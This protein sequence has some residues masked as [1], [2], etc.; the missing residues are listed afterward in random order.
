M[1]LLLLIAPLTLTSYADSGQKVIK[2]KIYIA[3]RFRQDTLKWSLGPF[4]L[5]ERHGV[6]VPAKYF[7]LR[8]VQAALSVLNERVFVSQAN[9]IIMP[10]KVYYKT[11][12][13]LRISFNTGPV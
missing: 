8:P 7:I 11:N 4:C 3:F 10:L 5:T 6:Y 13:R 1:L 12:K 9:L 2:L